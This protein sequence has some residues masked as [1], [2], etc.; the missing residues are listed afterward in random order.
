MVNICAF[1]ILRCVSPLLLRIRDFRIERGLTQEALAHA[2]GVRV[3]TIS[4]L[5]NNR[6]RRIELDLLERLA[7][8]LGVQPGDMFEMGDT[9][10]RHR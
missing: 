10:R 3:A 4:D 5:E 6:S 1:C 7:S 9:P 2:V 8:A